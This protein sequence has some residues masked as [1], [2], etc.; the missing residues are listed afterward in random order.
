MEQHDDALGPVGAGLATGGDGTLAVAL[1]GLPQLAV[2]RLGLGR[3]E[4]QQVLI[5]STC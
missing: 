5:S 2:E 1:D 4:D 3:V